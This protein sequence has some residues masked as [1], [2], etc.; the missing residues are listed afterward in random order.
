M[1]YKIMA[2]CLGNICR[3]PLAEGHLSKVAKDRDLDWEVSSGGTGNWHVGAKPDPR[4]REI[5]KQHGMNID[6][7]RGHQVTVHDL[8]T[9]DLVLAMDRS[10]YQHLLTLATSDAQKAKIKL[11][12]DYTN[13]SQANGPDV[14]DPYWD[15]SG[16]EGVYRLLE[17]AASRVADLYEEEK[18][19]EKE[20]ST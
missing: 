18:E 12:L 19:K 8:D 16:F 1:P 17:N 5:A 10:N 7:Q 13:L 11:L 14:F 6:D 3:S 2:V 20:T 4:S 9:N 15:D